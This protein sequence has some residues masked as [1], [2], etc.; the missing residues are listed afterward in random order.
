M[1]QH[2]SLNLAAP[3]VKESV[4]F[5]GG[6]RAGERPRQEDYFA[7]FKDECFA[8]ADGVGSVPHSDLAAQLAVETALWGYKHIRQRPFYWRDKKLFM[9]R[10]FRSAN[11]TLW[12]KHREAEFSEGLLTTL[13]VV[14]IGARNFWLGSVGDTSA[15]LY[16]ESLIA[17]LTTE[18]V[19]LSGLLTKVLGWQRFGLRP[20][21][22]AEPFLAGDILLLA[23]DGVAQF[24]AEE[25]L[26]E[27][28][29]NAGNT[30][31]EL[32]GAV[33]KILTLAQENGSRDNLTAVLIKKTSTSSA[34]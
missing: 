23:T 22:L 15:F 16:R 28:L 14:M 12:Q 29:E 3:S 1:K 31:N 34:I 20:Q 30:A 21:F 25:E 24:L 33:G 5:A 9:Q 7:N 8:L 26:R 4:V 13:L 6:Q 17:K 27:V 32:G 2:A 19:N 18:D 11:L 10:I